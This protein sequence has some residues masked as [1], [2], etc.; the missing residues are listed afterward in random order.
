MSYF[1]SAVG[2]EPRGGGVFCAYPSVGSALGASKHAG[3]RS[4]GAPAGPGPLALTGT[5]GTGKSSVAALLRPWYSVVEVGEFARRA[6]LGSGVRRA[7]VVDLARL[8]QRFRRLQRERPQDVYVGHLAHLLPV[9]DVVVLRC[10]PL[11][12]DRRLRRA[13]RGRA[14]ER[15]A[16]VGS[17]AID[18]VLREAIGPGRRVWEVDTTGRSPR[19]V[20]SEVRRRLR[21]RGPSSYGHVRWLAD[22]TVTDYLLDAGP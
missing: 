2:P 18:L 5:P 15:E 7:V 14:R 22:P 4:A 13:R 10:H 17:E 21:R 20:A 12:L 16:N 19:Q 1:S 3:G 8:R 6:G 9:R 11:E